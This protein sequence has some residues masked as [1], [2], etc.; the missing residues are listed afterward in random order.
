MASWRSEY[1]SA[2]DERDKQEKAGRDIF[3]ACGN[4]PGTPDVIATDSDFLDN[5][6]ADR[7]AT[8]E[9]ASSTRNATVE[10]GSAAS[11]HPKGRP[12]SA[13]DLRSSSPAQPEA[14][15]RLRQD[16]TEAQRTK[17]EQQSRLKSVTDELERLKA[18]SRM[19]TQRIGELAT[20]KAGL[21]TRIRDR[22]E[23][24]REKAKLLEVLRNLVTTLPITILISTCY[25]MFTMRQYH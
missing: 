11:L 20:E 6:L 3:D 9:A 22:D 21:M 17:G 16:L 5:K 2:L 24:L 1:M 14:L 10:G 7:A 25:R 13:A 8:L 4:C 18:K 15:A 12:T 23:E 19:D